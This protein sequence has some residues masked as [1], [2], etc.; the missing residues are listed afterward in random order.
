MKELHHEC[1]MMVD[2][3][4]KGDIGEFEYW[5]PKHHEVPKSECEYK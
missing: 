4:K 5:C 3:E 1:G 2:V